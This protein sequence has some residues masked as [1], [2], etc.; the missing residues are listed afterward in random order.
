M[1]K[2]D[3]D[4][5]RRIEQTLASARDGLWSRLDRRLRYALGAA[6]IGLAGLLVYSV[7]GG[8]GAAARYLTEAAARSDLTVMIS[9][10]GSV[11][12]TNQVDVSSELSGMIRNVN[13]DYNSPVKSGQVLAE[14]DT[15]KLRAT[16]ESSRAKL[17]AAKA[18]V[19]DAKATLIEK[20]RELAR[21]RALEARDV[22]TTHDLDAA[23]AAFDRA[24][25]A[26]ASREADVGVAEA[27]LRL[28]ETNLAKACICSPIDGVVL[29]RNV[30]PGQTVASSFQAPVL[31]TIAE[32]LTKMEIRIDVDEADVGKV[33]VD[34]TATFAVDAY[35]DRRFPARIREVR[36]A[37]E[38]VQG[39]VTYKAI[40]AID[41]SELLLR[42]G[43]TATAE[44]VVAHVKGAL[45][46]PN[47]AL[48]F[49]PSV[50]EGSQGNDGLLRRV[51]PGPPRFRAASKRDDGGTRRP[52]W[53]LRDGK[54]AEVSVEIGATDGRVTEIRGGDLQEGDKV[55]VDAAR[56]AES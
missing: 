55:I 33:R 42:P 43:M 38:V 7:A 3:T 37:S 13:V 11:Q 50:E 45:V 21:K 47:A 12:P 31:F 52:L 16:V 4:L 20:E 30:D 15:D 25:A 29:V 18:H 35:P 26:L 36:Y 5:A 28:N 8:D 10:T 2:P 34:Q 1:S 48:R 22:A 39:V 46:V 40:L 32:D 44:V 51:L 19:A 54:A 9:A 17:A 56:G 27:D 49:S 41:N 6:A 53:V 14:L 23:K 24:V